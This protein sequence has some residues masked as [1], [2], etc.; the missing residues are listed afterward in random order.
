MVSSPVKHVSI[1]PLDGSFGPDRERRIVVAF[2]PGKKSA[3][4]EADVPDTLELRPLGTRRIERL[5][6]ID[7][8]RYALRCR[9]GR[10]LLE[11]ARIAKSRRALRLAAQRLERAE[12]RLIR[13][14]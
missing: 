1:V 4:E 8:Y 5:A 12:K 11:K 9:V 7:V 6:V 10:A 2:V 14:S 13:K 3:R